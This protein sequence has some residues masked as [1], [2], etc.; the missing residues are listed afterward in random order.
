MYAAVRRKAERAIVV[1]SPANKAQ[2]V[3]LNDT[4]FRLLVGKNRSWEGFRKGRSNGSE[5]KSMVK[6]QNRCFFGSE[7]PMIDSLIRKRDKA[8]GTIN[9]ESQTS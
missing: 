2:N 3:Q 8:Q 1:A 9:C 4:R 5:I 6:L 7:L